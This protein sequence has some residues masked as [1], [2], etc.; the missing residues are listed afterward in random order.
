MRVGA[1][2]NRRAD[3]RRAL[4]RVKPDDMLPLTQLALIWGVTKPRFVTVRNEMADFP[5]PRKGNGNEYEYAA[6]PAL[7][8]M[9]RHE[10]RHDA[11]AAEK[12]ARTAAILGHT[13]RGRAGTDVGT[14][15]PNELA[16]LNRLAADIEERER[17]QGLYVPVA[18]NAAVATEIFGE[19]SEFMSSITN[20]IDPHGLIDATVRARIDAAAS[21]ALMGLHKRMKELLSPDAQPRGNRAKAGRSRSARARR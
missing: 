16:T 1:S 20:R 13:Q 7:E 18:E 9:L 8:A 3:I 15:T 14:H 17:E 21:D 6:R 4:R 11:A 2:Q 19:I 10:T 12:Q 5:P